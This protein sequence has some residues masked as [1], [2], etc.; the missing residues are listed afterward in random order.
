MTK[1]KECE[2]LSKDYG[3][4]IVIRAI[5]ANSILCLRKKLLAST[6]ETAS[7]AS[8]IRRPQYQPF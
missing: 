1:G 5:R 3:F 8:V 4:T 6:A 7:I 2:T